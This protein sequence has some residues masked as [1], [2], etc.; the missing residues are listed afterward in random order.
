M[1]AK[2][3]SMDW[4]ASLDNAFSDVLSKRNVLLLALFWGAGLFLVVSYGTCWRRMHRADVAPLVVQRTGG[5]NETGTF[6][7]WRP[8]A[9]DLSRPSYRIVFDNLAAR[10]RSLGIFRTAS[11]KQVHIENLHVTFHAP[12]TAVPQEGMGVRLRDFC[13]L[14]TPRSV[15]G[16]GASE[17]AVFDELVAGDADWSV[18]VDLSNATEVRISDLDWRVCR[19]GVT[20]LRVQCRLASLQADTA[21]VILRGHVTVT[22]PERMLESNCIEMDGDKECF[23]VGGRYLL[24]R[25]ARQERGDRGQFNATLRLLEAES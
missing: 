17:L 19:D 15:A 9:S 8:E 24:T 12:E 4:K 2:A 6:S 7:T 25:G 11:H 14:F 18:G 16:T 10:D 3:R 22:T 1:E 20:V 23:V 5:A 13:D 21:R